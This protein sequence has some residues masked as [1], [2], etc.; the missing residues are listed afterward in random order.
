MGESETV[1]ASCLRV[2]S[3]CGVIWSIVIGIH[4]TPA[5]PAA[6][7]NVQ[8]RHDSRVHGKNSC[9]VCEVCVYGVIGYMDEKLLDS[10][11]GLRYIRDL[12]CGIYYAFI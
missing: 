7:S 5:V 12:R 3:I 9:T 6:C 11:C 1:P 10:C 8:E 2:M 4:Q